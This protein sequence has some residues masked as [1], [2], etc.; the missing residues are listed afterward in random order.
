MSWEEYGFRLGD[1]IRIFDGLNSLATII[2]YAQPESEDMYGRIRV[3]VDGTSVRQEF[4]FK[5]SDILTDHFEK[6]E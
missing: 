5:T 2:E 1:R 4:T 6:V 3:N